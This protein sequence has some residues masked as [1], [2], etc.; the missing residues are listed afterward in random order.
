MTEET[1]GYLLD[2]NQCELRLKFNLI[3]SINYKNIGIESHF[4]SLCSFYIFHF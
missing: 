2:T 3:K 1:E 4:I